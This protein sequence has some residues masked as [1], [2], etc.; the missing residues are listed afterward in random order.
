MPLFRGLD[1]ALLPLLR[2][3]LGWPPMRVLGSGARSPL[4]RLLPEAGDDAVTAAVVARIAG[5]GRATVT[6]WR[7]RHTDFPTPTGGTPK[8]PVFDRRAVG[9]WLL[10]HGKITLTE[11]VPAARLV[12]HTGLGVD[13]RADG[14]TTADAGDVHRLVG[15]RRAGLRGPR[16]ARPTSTSWRLGPPSGA[17]CAGSS[18]RGRGRAPALRC[19]STPDRSPGR[20]WGRRAARARKRSAGSSWWTT[21]VVR[22]TGSG[23][24]ARN[25]TPSRGRRPLPRT[26]GSPRGVGR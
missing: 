16:S 14:L 18:C 20:P 21:A 1:V 13:L 22:I 2:P 23:G 5:V 19:A 7:R 15:L 9:E 3:E 25:G 6:A 12:L 26:H 8:S 24:P 17:G 11:A 10:D 4:S